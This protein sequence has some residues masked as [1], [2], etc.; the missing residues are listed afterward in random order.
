MHFTFFKLLSI[1]NISRKADK[2]GIELPFLD[3]LYHFC[4]CMTFIT[5]FLCYT[6]HAESLPFIIVNITKNLLKS[7]KVTS[8]SG[9]THTSQLTSISELISTSG[10][11]STSVFIRSSIFAQIDS[12]SNTTGSG[13]IITTVFP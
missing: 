7:V 12:T 4:L 5:Y 6:K 9:L 2:F 13:N 3:C 8:T 10:L 1:Q 11:T